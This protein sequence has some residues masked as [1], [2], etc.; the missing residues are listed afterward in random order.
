MDEVQPPV[1]PVLTRFARRKGVQPPTKNS[2]E[3]HTRIHEVGSESL[4]GLPQVCSGVPN[5]N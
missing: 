5:S 4:S 1:A 3:E 2:H